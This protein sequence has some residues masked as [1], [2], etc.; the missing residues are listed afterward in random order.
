VQEA[1]GS[2]SSFNPIEGSDSKKDR[3]IIRWSF[4][5]RGGKKNI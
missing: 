3:P 2:W 4:Y 5:T 1:V